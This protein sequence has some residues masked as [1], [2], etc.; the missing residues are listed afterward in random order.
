MGVKRNHSPFLIIKYPETLVRVIHATLFLE[1]GYGEML[2]LLLR[3]NSQVLGKVHDRGP[4]PES[5]CFTCQFRN[6]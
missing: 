5:H 2:P 3:D 1:L 6:T 4:L